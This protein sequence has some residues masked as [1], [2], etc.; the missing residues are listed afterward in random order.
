[1]IRPQW[2]VARAWISQILSLSKHPMIMFACIIFWLEYHL[3]NIDGKTYSFLS[4]GECKIVLR[5]KVSFLNPFHRA[6]NLVSYASILV[7]TVPTNVWGK[8]LRFPRSLFPAQKSVLVAEEK[9]GSGLRERKGKS[10]KRIHIRTMDYVE[11]RMKWKEGMSLTF[12]RH[13]FG[14]HFSA[15]TT[16][17]WKSLSF[18]A[19]ITSLHSFFTFCLFFL[20]VIFY[21]LASLCAVSKP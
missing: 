21:S 2:C 1:M 13:I 9:A 7:V 6:E 18:F 12:R 3:R 16:I 4:A 8:P 11:R 14:S 20:R 10:K 19:W 5:L 15:Q 17:V